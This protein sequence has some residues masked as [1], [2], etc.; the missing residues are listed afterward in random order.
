[1]NA[2]KEL[3]IKNNVFNGL[4][5]DIAADIFLS[6]GTNLAIIGNHFGHTVPA[7]AAGSMT[8]YIFCIGGSTVT[9]SASGNFFASANAG[10]GTDN[11]NNAEIKRSGNFYSAG[12]MTS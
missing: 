7:H 9:G 3:V 2:W 5:A 6:D 1:M 12:L 10:Y 4:A 8:K 11:T